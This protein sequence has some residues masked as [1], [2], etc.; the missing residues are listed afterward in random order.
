MSIFYPVHTVRSVGSLDLQGK[1][2]NWPIEIDR[3][4]RIEFEPILAITPPRATET[5][6]DALPPRGEWLKYFYYEIS[7]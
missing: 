1:R 4:R 3:N 7:G 5:G 2:W 6:Q